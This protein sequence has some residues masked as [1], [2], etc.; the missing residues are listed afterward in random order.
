MKSKV[1]VCKGPSGREYDLYTDMRES[2]NELTDAVGEFNMFVESVMKSDASGS[3]E[4]FITEFLD[5]AGQVITCVARSSAILPIAVVVCERYRKELDPAEWDRWL[6]R[7]A[8]FTGME[9]V[10]LKEKEIDYGVDVEEVRN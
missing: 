10:Q 2:Y 9:D 5:K 4:D 1:L 7:S 8:G 3:T 6:I